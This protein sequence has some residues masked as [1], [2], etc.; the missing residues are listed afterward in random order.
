MRMQL[1]RALKRMDTQDMEL[2]MDLMVVLSEK[3]GRNVDN[4][5]LQRLANKLELWTLC[6][7]KAEAAAIRKLVKRFGKDAQIIRQITGLF[8]K[9][10]WIAGYEEPNAPDCSFSPRTL[11][12]LPSFSVPHEF[13]CSIALEIMTDPVIVATGQVIPPT[14]AKTHAFMQNSIT[15]SSTEK[16]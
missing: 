7:L 11:E 15:S 8:G 14:T 10:K 2:A 5:I 3:D 6:D 4:A 1:K 12:K 16:L 13:L 9:F